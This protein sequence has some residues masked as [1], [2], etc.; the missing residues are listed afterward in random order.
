MVALIGGGYFC[1]GIAK[2]LQI[3]QIKSYSSII[4]C[5][6]SCF[7]SSCKGVV[8]ANVSLNDEITF[9]EIDE[10]KLKVDFK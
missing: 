10:I 1:G 3:D 2:I 5:S 7:Q 6:F 8:E 4:N 9:K